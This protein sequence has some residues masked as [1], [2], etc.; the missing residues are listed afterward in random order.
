MRTPSRT[1]TPTPADALAGDP[2]AASHRTTAR[3]VGGFYILATAAGVAALAAEQPVLNASDR[4]AQ[5]HLHQGRVVTGALLEMVMGLAVTAVSISIHPVLRRFGER[6]ALGYV[7]AR[8][9]EGAFYLASAVGLLTIVALSRTSADGTDP[10]QSQR[11]ADLV[12][13][14]RDLLFNAGVAVFVVS[15]FILYWTLFRTRLVDRPRLQHIGPV[16][17]LQAPRTR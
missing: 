7:V 5:A 13:T 12:T 6:L 3:L 10:A 4:L 11:S 8:S 9:V 1:A 16:C 17:H 14:Q 2:P 15:A